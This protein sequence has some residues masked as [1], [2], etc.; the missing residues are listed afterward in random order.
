MS[1]ECSMKIE[2]IEESWAKDGPID[3]LNVTNES[4][5]TPKLHNKYFS[6]YV[7][8]NLALKK[9][10]AELS[11]LTKLKAEYYRGELDTDELKEH[12]WEPFRLRILKQDV[13]S[14]I[15]SDGDIIKLKLKIG[16]MESVVEYLESIIKQINTRGFQLKTITDWERFKAGA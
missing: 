12:G 8:E 3:I 5:N 16:Y 15:E 1:T 4:A 9:T 13:P 14:Y 10:R 6:M 7:R 11:I 2:E